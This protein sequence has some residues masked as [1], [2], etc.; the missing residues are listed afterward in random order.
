M[1]R[2]CTGKIQVALIFFIFPEKKSA[3]TIYFTTSLEGVIVVRSEEMHEKTHKGV[4]V[5]DFLFVN[6]QTGISQRY[7]ELTSS[8]IIF[9]DFD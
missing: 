4:C 5:N 6:L 9:R 7:Y 3:R 1:N 2:N 8:Q